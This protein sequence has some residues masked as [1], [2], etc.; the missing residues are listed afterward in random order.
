[1]APKIKI[2]CVVDN[3][4]KFSSR[5]WGEHGLAF[6]IQ[7]GANTILFDSGSSPDILEHNMREL[8]EDMSRVKYIVLSHGHYDHCGGLEWAL[9]KT[10]RPLIIA[11][12]SIFDKKLIRVDKEFVSVGIPI[13]AEQIREKGDIKFIQDQHYSIAQGVFV[14]GRIPRT[15]PFEVIPAGKDFVEKKMMI[16]EDPF[17]DDHALVMDS[18]KGQI[19]ILGCCH[20]GLINTLTYVSK[21]WQKPLLAIIGGT[22]LNNASGDRVNRTIVPLREKFKPSTLCLNHCTGLEAFFALRNSF[23]A[24]VKD[25]PAGSVIEF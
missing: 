19:V 18:D 6:L 7:A 14:T 8:G 24:S 10:R 12:D 5:L 9:S 11:D 17:L 23:G 13:T 20:A 22:H 1:M 16:E 2:T 4:A 15:I 25:F 3:C 21:T